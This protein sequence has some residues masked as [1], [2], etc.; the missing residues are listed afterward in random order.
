MEKDKAC[1]KT[2]LSQIQHLGCLVQFPQ[3]AF[4]ITIILFF[5]AALPKWWILLN[6]CKFSSWMKLLMVS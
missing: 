2:T 6:L 4:Y 1:F 5:P 3:R